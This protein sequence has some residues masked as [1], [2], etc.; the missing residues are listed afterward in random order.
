MSAMNTSS[1]D[2]YDAFFVR[3]AEPRVEPR[4]EDEPGWPSLPVYAPS[5]KRS[6]RLLAA[7]GTVFDKPLVLQNKL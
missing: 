1:Y 5:V 6:R 7:H 2:P 3:P 4:K